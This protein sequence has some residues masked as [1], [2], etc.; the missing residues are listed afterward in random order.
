[1]R[2]SWQVEEQFRNN[3]HGHFIIS[4]AA[5][6]STLKAFLDKLN[7][8]TFISVKNV[9][10]LAENIQCNSVMSNPDVY[11]SC[12]VCENKACSAVAPHTS[13]IFETTIDSDIVMVSVPGPDANVATGSS[14]PQP[15][16]SEPIP[17]DVLKTTKPL[18]FHFPSPNTVACDVCQTKYVGHEVL[19]RA[20]LIELESHGDEFSKLVKAWK[21]GNDDYG[22]RT[23]ALWVD[24][25]MDQLHKP[26]FQAV[27]ALLVL[28]YNRHRAGHHRSCFKLRIQGTCRFNLPMDATQLT[29]LLINNMEIDKFGNIVFHDVDVREQGDILATDNDDTSSNPMDVDRVPLAA[30]AVD[31]AAA[32]TPMTRM[33]FIHTL[34]VDK[35]TAM[36]LDVHRQIGSEYINRFNPIVM[37]TFGWNNDSTTMF[38]SPG[39][40]HYITNYVSKAPDAGAAGAATIRAFRQTVTKREREAAASQ[41][42]AQR[43]ASASAGDTTDPPESSHPTGAPSKQQLSQRTVI[44]TLLGASRTQEVGQNIVAYSALF[45]STDLHSHESTNVQ[46]PQMLAFLRGEPISGV[47]SRV[48]PLASTSNEVDGDGAQP[49]EDEDD[50]ANRDEEEGPSNEPNPAPMKLS[51]VP[52]VLISSST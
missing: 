36:S 10:D 19:E 15:L 1:M 14:A 34:T 12:M 43:H 16:R 30:I 39:I 11:K 51:A 38:T 32:P 20:A 13:P 29:T 31:S 44:A 2:D 35:I 50:G 48:S 4:L 33:P 21:S 24:L 3:L 5:A 25:D 37:I 45:D 49:R 18:G 7:N 8:S 46:V 6:P 52:Q 26:K 22:V 28:Q 40:I 23:E 41:A 9:I 27:L 47:M 42:E 17:D